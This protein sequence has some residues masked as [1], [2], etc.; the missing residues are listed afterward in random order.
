MF[1]IPSDA[2]RILLG[3]AIDLG[4]TG[5]NH[6]SPVKLPNWGISETVAG[7]DTAFTNNPYGQGT[8]ETRVTQPKN[9]STR[10]KSVN[11][12]QP[13]QAGGVNYYSGGATGASQ[14]A[15]NP[16]TIAQLD[17]SISL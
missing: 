1:G 13:A 14:P 12:D 5:F 2:G 16:E 4:A 10:V 6:V 7:T 8:G 3:N 15:Y 11:N 9:D 17:Q